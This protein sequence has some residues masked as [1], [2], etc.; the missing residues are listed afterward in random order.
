VG[1]HPTEGTRS[2]QP[3]SEVEGQLL[4]LLQEPVVAGETPKVVQLPEQLLELFEVTVPTEDEFA[5]KLVSRI[6]SNKEDN[7]KG[8]ITNGNAI[9]SISCVRRLHG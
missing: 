7:G 9:P 6:A 5:E 8:T 3:A 4:G 1:W 2:S